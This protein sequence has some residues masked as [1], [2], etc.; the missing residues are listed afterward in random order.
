MRAHTQSPVT[1]ALHYC[2]MFSWCYSLILEKYKPEHALIFL[3]HRDLAFTQMLN[4]TQGSDSKPRVEGRL[5]SCGPAVLWREFSTRLSRRFVAGCA[6]YIQLPF[7]LTLAD[8]LSPGPAAH[9]RDSS[10]QIQARFLCQMNPFDDPV[11]SGC[12]FLKTF[13]VLTF[14]G[15]ESKLY[16]ENGC[17]LNS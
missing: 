12:D 9:G 17:R 6:F 5:W 4:R 3:D 14:W 15:L 16:F 11:V 1:G 8:T 7:W 13:L 10:G 2:A